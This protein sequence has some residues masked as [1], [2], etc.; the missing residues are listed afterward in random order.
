VSWG[1][2]REVREVVGASNWKMVYLVARSTCGGGRPKSDEVVLASPTGQGL[3]SSLGKLHSLSGKPSK[4]SGEAGVDGKGWPR[5][6][7]SGSCGGRW[8][9]PFT[10]NSGDHWLGQGFGCTSEYD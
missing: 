3:G 10:A 1:A 9:L 5:R 6:S 8:R 4:G 2:S 7:G